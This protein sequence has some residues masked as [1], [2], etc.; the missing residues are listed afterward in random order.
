MIKAVIDT[1]VI[2]SA[3]L[4]PNSK[5]EQILYLAEAGKIDIYLSPQILDELEATLLSPKLMKLHKDTPEQVRH[6]IRLLKKYVKITPGDLEV[7]VIINDPDDNKILACAI[8]GQVDYIISGDHHLTDL[9][10]FQ[11]IPIVNPD[12]FLK[13]LII[14]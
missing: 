4:T 11:G 9:K 10:S 3:H 5:A 8:E 13:K 2:V 6:S 14:H 7:E 1:N 12:M